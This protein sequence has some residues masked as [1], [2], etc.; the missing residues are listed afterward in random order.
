MFLHANPGFETSKDS[1]CLGE[2]MICGMIGKT[3]ESLE[4]LC[5]C[6]G[7][8]GRLLAES[9]Q[10]VYP[11][12]RKHSIQYV[13]FNSKI[14]PFWYDNTFRLKNTILRVLFSDSYDLPCLARPDCVRQECFMLLPESIQHIYK[15]D[16]GGCF[17]C[18]ELSSLLTLAYTHTSA[19][20]TYLRFSWNPK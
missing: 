4:W 15:S 19:L 7:G 18:H 2:G 14:L 16:L 3:R 17:V 9:L 11:S 6:G 20:L 5:A 8:V 13:L 10:V 1:T 12:E